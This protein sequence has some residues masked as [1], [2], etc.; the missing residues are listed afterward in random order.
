[1]RLW[2][3]QSEDFICKVWPQ[4]PTDYDN[5]FCEDVRGPL[6]M[7]Y[8]VL[9]TKIVFKTFSYT[10]AIK[11]HRDLE[12]QY[13]KTRVKIKYEEFKHEALDNQE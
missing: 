13:P 4:E 5:V 12:Y 10:R 6:T 7:F 2:Y 9:G 3:M 1:M 11:L 8:V